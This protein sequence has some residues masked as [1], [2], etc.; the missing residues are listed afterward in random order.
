MTQFRIAQG[1]TCR[2][3]PSN[4]DLHL[5]AEASER[6][7]LEVLLWLTLRSL[8]SIQKCSCTI[9]R[10]GASSFHW[11]QNRMRRT[12]ILSDAFLSDPDPSPSHTAKAR[13]LKQGFQP[14]HNYQAQPAEQASPGTT[15]IKHSS[16]TSPTYNRKSPR[17]PKKSC[18][19]CAR[20]PTWP[21]RQEWT[22]SRSSCGNTT[23]PPLSRV[24]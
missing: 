1:Q 7:L 9:C 5:S 12:R 15:H 17:S 14:K 8:V 6:A 20:L 18:K 10:P 24:P 13:K 4:E 2:C 22:P 21:R 3:Y 16:N 19:C 11:R 23:T